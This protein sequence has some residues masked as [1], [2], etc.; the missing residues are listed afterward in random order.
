VQ[1]LNAGG[2]FISTPRPLQV[3]ASLR[4]LFSIYEGEIRAQAI[5]RDCLKGE[6]M[7]VEF[8]SMENEDWQRLLLFLERLSGS[9]ERVW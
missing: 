2:V 5:V 6:G 1:G 7:G 4:L 9:F 3:G 8:V